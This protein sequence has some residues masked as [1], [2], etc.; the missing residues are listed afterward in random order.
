MRKYTK[1]DLEEIVFVQ[2][3][4]LN[5]MHDLLSIMKH[6]NALLE[7][8]NEKLRGELLGSSDRTYT[9]K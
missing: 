1:A 4:N 7:E 5:A 9:K 2:L 8:A 6:Q 3:E